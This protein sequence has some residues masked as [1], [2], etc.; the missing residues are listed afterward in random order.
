[1]AKLQESVNKIVH[2]EMARL[3][4]EAKERAP[5]LDKKLEE[6]RKKLV[7]DMKKEFE[8]SLQLASLGRRRERR[9]ELKTVSELLDVPINELMLHF[10]NNVKTK[11]ERCLVE[12]HLGSVVFYEDV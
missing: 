5:D 11:N 3:I 4:K 6:L 10:M 2:E 1:M 9:I 7:P 8:E 12:Y